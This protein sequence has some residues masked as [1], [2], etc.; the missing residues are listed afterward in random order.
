MSLLALLNHAVNF[1]ALAVWLAFLVP[2]LSR[3]FMRKTPVVQTLPRQVAINFIVSMLV[4]VVGL[5]VFGRDGKMLTYLAMVLCSATVQWA[6][7][8]AR[9]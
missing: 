5:L 7:V 2:L 3:I 1:F 4:L 8:K 6:M 9:R